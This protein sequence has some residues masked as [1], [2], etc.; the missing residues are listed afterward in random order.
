MTIK[1]YLSHGI[2]HRTVREALEST[3]L[4]FFNKKTGEHSWK[5][6]KAV[7]EGGV[8]PHWNEVEFDSMEQ[9]LELFDHHPEVN[10]KRVVMAGGWIPSG[11][12]GRVPFIGDRSNLKIGKTDKWT[13]V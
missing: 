8:E 12:W 3:F 9:A 11:L 7:K 10:R 2:H 5:N 6:I 1:I 4:L 13:S